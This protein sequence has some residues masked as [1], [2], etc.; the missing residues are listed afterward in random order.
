M[1]FLPPPADFSVTRLRVLQNRLRDSMRHSAAIETAAADLA[2][3]IFDE[4]PGQVALARVFATIPFERLPA[5][6]RRVSLSL[7]TAKDVAGLL[8]PETPVLSLLASRGLLPEWNDRR[9]SERHVGIPLVSQDF[10]RSTPMVATLLSELGYQLDGLDPYKGRA[11][12]ERLIGGESAGTMYVD[13]AKS[14]L[15]A[16]KRKVVPAQDFVAAHGVETVFAIGGCW[17]NQSLAACIVFMRCP[18]SRTFVRRIAPV[19]SVFRAGTTPLAMHDRYFLD[20]SA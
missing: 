2:Q 1:A 9:R 3:L 5:F 4:F 12:T 19:L 11:L 20:K 10:V 13:D 15:D 6:N 17:P 8:R 7:A 16:L 18:L 14:A